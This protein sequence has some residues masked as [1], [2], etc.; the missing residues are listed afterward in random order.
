MAELWPTPALHARGDGSLESPGEKESSPTAIGTGGGRHDPRCIPFRG[1][2]CLARWSELLRQP[3]NGAH[4]NAIMRH[5]ASHRYRLEDGSEAA[6]NLAN[7]RDTS[8]PHLRCPD[9]L[10]GCPWNSQTSRRNGRSL[11]NASLEGPD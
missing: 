6:A 10:L 8:N 7:G 3:P 2:K 11:A 1:R 9:T 4:G 5:R